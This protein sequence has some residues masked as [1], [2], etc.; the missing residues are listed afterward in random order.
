M[1]SLIAASGMELLEVREDSD[2]M[3]FVCRKGGATGNWY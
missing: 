2:R 1:E 3:F